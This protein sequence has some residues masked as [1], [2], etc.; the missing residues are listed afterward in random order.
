L[1]AS[2]YDIYEEYKEAFALSRTQY[3]DFLV[4][5]IPDIY[6][7]ARAE[8]TNETEGARD[9]YDTLKKV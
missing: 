7:R 3:S 9:H 1:T 6:A 4:A 8:S 2:K 5:F